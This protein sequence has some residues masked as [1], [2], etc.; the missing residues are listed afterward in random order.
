MLLVTSVAWGQSLS[1]IRNSL[2]KLQKRQPLDISLKIENRQYFRSSEPYF[3]ES[4]EDQSNS[5]DLSIK[6]KG[7]NGS[8]VSGIEVADTYEVSEDFHY[9]KP[10]EF[11]AGLKSGSFQFSVGRRLNT[12]SQADDLWRLGVWQPRFTEDKLEREVAGLTGAFAQLSNENHKFLIFGSGLYVP[13]MGA[14]MDVE[15]DQFKSKNPWFRPPTS[16]VMINDKPTLVR[17][18]FNRPTMGDVVSHGSVA[19]Q[20][21]SRSPTGKFVRMS[22][23]H[24]PLNQILI[25]GPIE[26][27]LPDPP[28]AFVEVNARVVYHDLYTFEV[29]ELRKGGFHVWASITR[30]NPIR[31]NTPENWTTQEAVSTNVWSTYLGYDL[32]E[33]GEQPSHVYLSY[34]RVDG[35]D[36]AVRGTIETNESIFERRYY[37]QDAVQAGFHHSFSS[38]GGMA[39][40]VTTFLYEVGQHG[41]I[42]STALTQSLDRN[43]SAQIS[44]DFLG[45][46]DTN[47]PVKDGFTSLYRANDRAQVGVQYVF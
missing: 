34:L 39:T 1:E 29:G 36:G 35:G 46:L 19:A 3:R 45:L 21:E 40:L 44:L 22:Y 30:D 6:G 31:D 27:L 13:D 16:L 7:T 23:A 18:Q 33:T 14:N 15:Q 28:Y 2:P 41:T 9:I 4:A 32:S 10:K 5:F 24:K 12:W 11:F 25:G 43:W 47:G 42:F 38:L 17:Y 37:F 8:L 26:L 20:Y